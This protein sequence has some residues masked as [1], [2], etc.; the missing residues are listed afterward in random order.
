M[1]LPVRLIVNAD[2]FGLTAG[3]NR[4]IAELAQA[5]ALSAATLMAAGAAF[6]NSI[7]IANAI[8]G[9]KIGCHVVLVD[10]T[11]CAAPGTVPTLAAKD[12]TFRSSLLR[13][14]VD[15]Q[16]G[17]I[18]EAEIE[19][20][21]S[22][23]INR[24]QA[25]GLSVSH[26]DTHKHTHLF[27]RVARPLLRAAMRCGVK[28]IRNPFEPAW[29]VR[30][31]QGAMLRKLQVA[32]LN[33]FQQRFEQLRRASG[34]LSTDGAIG[35]CATGHLD[36]A[37][38]R[39]LLAAAPGG[40]WELVCHPGYNDA[41]LHAVKTR[42]RSTREVEREALLEVIPEAVRAGRIQLIRFSDL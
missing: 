6:A 31:T 33:S 7:D 2:D 40:T 20:E 21:A 39:R 13:F 36:A 38:L 1:G 9:A 17:R 23:Q 41:A 12:G 27:P 5:G 34:L 8:P 10:G 18:A 42:L 37:A 14:A 29:S 30:A 22:A 19:A 28:A 32:A 26:V 4:A 35:V 11:A 3:V 15:L 24:L 25:A 16:R